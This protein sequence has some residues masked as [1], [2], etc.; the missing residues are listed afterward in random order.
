[1]LLSANYSKNSMTEAMSFVV[2]SFSACARL[3]GERA[4][5]IKMANVGI[6]E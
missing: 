5:C 3:T 6:E 2:I 4:V 1:M